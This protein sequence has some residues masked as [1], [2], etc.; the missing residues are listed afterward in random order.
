MSDFVETYLAFIVV[1]IIWL[2]M[3]I[4]VLLVYLLFPPGI[5]YWDK[6]CDKCTISTANYRYVIRFVFGSF[7]PAFQ[8]S[9][10]IISVGIL[11]SAKTVVVLRIQPKQ[12]EQSVQ[13]RDSTQLRE[14][15]FL[16]YRLEPLSDIRHVVVNHNGQ[17]SINVSF[18]EIQDLASREANIAYVG[19]AINNISK[20]K[21]SNT[22]QQ[23]PAASREPRDIEPE[24][25]TGQTMTALEYMLLIFVSINYILLQTIFIIPCIDGMCSDYRNEFVDSL[26]AGLLA[27]LC[28]T[29]LFVCLCVVYRY[30]IK[31]LL[32]RSKSSMVW[33]GIRYGFLSVCMAAGIAFGGASLFLTLQNRHSTEARQITSKTCWLIGVGLAI[34]VYGLFWLPI[35]SIVGFLFGFFN[36]P[37]TGSD[38]KGPEAGAGAEIKEAANIDDPNT[39]RTNMSDEHDY[40]NQLTKGNQ[41]VKSISQY[42]GLHVKTGSKPSTAGGS[43]DSGGSGKQSSADKSSGVKKSKSTESIGDRYY[44]QLIGKDAKVKSVSQY[45]GVGKK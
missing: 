11:D 16:L 19:Q 15:R 38:H 17:A 32:Y 5:D 36:E 10:T 25:T 22:V 42:K 8:I 34:V 21:V 41:R 39:T 43:K 27:S 18:I 26:F 6:M 9:K 30:L 40:Y 35:L 4:L 28:T 3:A 24:L 1:G 20:D 44:K 45:P 13:H 29:V 2:S 7:R 37:T 23:Y 31:R 33:V 12:L 14:C